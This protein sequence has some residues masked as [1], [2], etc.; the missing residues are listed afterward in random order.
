M[1]NLVYNINHSTFEQVKT[2]LTLC[3]K[4]F[5]PPL[6]TYV[7]IHDYSL[8]IYSLSTKFEAYDK[9]NN[10]V[11][12]IAIYLN[13]LNKTSFITNVS[14]FSKYY[15]KKIAEKLLSNCLFFLKKNDYTS[16][17]LEVNIDNKPAIS[18]YKKNLFTIIKNKNNKNNIVMELKIQRDYNQE[19]KD[20]FDHKYAYNFDFDIMH[21]YM[22]ESFKPFFNKG[23]CLELGSSKGD[24][25]KHIVDFFSDITCVEASDEA[26]QIAKKRLP[27]NINYINEL[28][29]NLDLDKK[30][31]NI[32][33]THVLEHIDDPVNLL[34]KIKM[35]WLSENGKLFIT[36][37]NANAAS[38]QIAVNMGLIPCNSFIT[39]SEQLHGHRITYSIDT[40]QRD[41]KKS[42]LNVLH[43]SGIFFKALSN[44]Q[45]DKIINTDIV[46]KEYLDGCY[47]LGKK[48]P[49]LCSSIFFVCVKN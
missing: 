24:F 26:I 2:H 32:I 28:F 42:N 45:W 49:D 38:R 6:E 33:L 16:V 23:N 35:N 15:G 19:L 31:D 30:F 3:N 37:P 44:F 20:T 34:K 17:T 8:K 1:T 21:P 36:C 22:V 12:L 41:I 25:T 14:V 39:E 29:E 47:Q 43:Y 48:Y 11:G 4:E 18:F 9:N 40:L 27:S 7:N 13:K 10:L 46:S 5:I